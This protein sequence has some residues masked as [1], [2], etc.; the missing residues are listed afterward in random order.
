MT[1]S[2]SPFLEGTNIQVAW[3]STSL[4]YLKICPRLYQYQMIEGWTTREESVHLRF[5]IEYHHALQD[6]DLSRAA[7]IQ[8]NDAVHDVIREL[9]LR[10][11]DFESDHK[12]KT[13][14]GLVRTVIWY[15]DQFRDDAAVTY[16]RPDGTPA[17]EVSFNFELDW[18]PQGAG[19]CQTCGG[20]GFSGPGTGYDNVCS[21]CGGQKLTGQPYILCGHLDAIVSYNSDL[22]IKDYKTVWSFWNKSWEPDNQMTLYTYAG[23]IVLNAPVRGVIIDMAQVKADG[24]TEFKRDLTYRTEDQL[25][26]WLADLRYWF[27]LAEQ[28]ATNNYWPMND[29]ACDKY[30]GCRF[31]D[32]CSK[33]PSA[34]QAFLEGNFTK[35]PE[36]Q[37]WNPLRAR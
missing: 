35:L 2:P 4:S 25:K 21:E 23:K 1:D 32:I 18:G 13:R 31:R 7:G 16:I 28:Y 29:T 15:L 20:S 11:A 14:E 37:R 22:Y 9:L 12:T 24:T 17:V 19:V 10:T 3:D 6:Y 8:H 26:E 36:D 5:G 27:A 33:S 34:R 30:G